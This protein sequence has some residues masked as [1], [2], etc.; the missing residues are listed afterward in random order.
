MTLKK[1]RY[2]NFLNLDYISFVILQTTKTRLFPKFLFGTK[3][4]NIYPLI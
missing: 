1:N 4:R 3:F 2:S